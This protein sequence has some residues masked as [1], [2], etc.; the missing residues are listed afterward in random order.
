MKNRDQ[1]ETQIVAFV[2]RRHVS[3][4]VSEVC[5][6]IAALHAE[7]LC[8]DEVFSLCLDLERAGRISFMMAADGTI[9]VY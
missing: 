4:T 8:S 5:L 9:N 6:A 3:Q 2:K 1:L 7:T